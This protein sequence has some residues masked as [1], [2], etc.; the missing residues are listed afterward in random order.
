MS[1]VIFVPNSNHCPQR[2][3]YSFVN[4]NFMILIYVLEIFYTNAD[5]LLNKLNELRLIIEASCRGV[6]VVTEVLPKNSRFCVGKS[7]FYLDGYRLFWN[8]DFYD[9]SKG[10][11]IYVGSYV[12]ATID[13]NLTCGGFAYVS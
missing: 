13:T 9:A 8:S 7:A 12:S 10:I 4:S 6:V 1:L 2:T 3:V 11:S 5:T